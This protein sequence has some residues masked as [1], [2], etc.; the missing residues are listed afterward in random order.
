MLK[1]SHPRATKPLALEDSLPTP[2]GPPLHIAMRRGT[3]MQPHVVALRFDPGVAGFFDKSHVFF[4][5]GE[6][7]YNPG[8]ANNGS[9]V[10][11]PQTGRISILAVSGWDFAA[12]TTIPQGIGARSQPA[13]IFC[14]P[15]VVYTH[16]LETLLG[17]GL[18][19]V[20]VSRCRQLHLNP[21][22]LGK[23]WPRIGSVPG[24]E[25]PGHCTTKDS[26]R[27]T[28]R[29][30]R[31]ERLIALL[32]LVSVVLLP[33]PA[34]GA[35]LKKKTLDA[36]NL[37]ARLTEERV[38]KEISGQG[39][40]LWVDGLPEARRQAVSTQMRN[41]QV[42]IEAQQ[43]R[44]SGKEIKVPDGIIHHWVGVAF[45]PGVKLM[46]A[47]SITLDY[48]NHVRTYRP[49]VVRSK[50]LQRDGDN[51]RMH[52]RFLKKKIITV[53]VDTEH[54]VH[55][56]RVDD[57]RAH[58]WSHTTRINEVED[59]GKK[60]ER[61]LPEGRDG[62]FM[63]RMYTYWR[64]LERDSG[65]YIQCESLTLTRDIPWGLGWLIRPYVTS[66]PR[67][68]L[69]FTMEKTRAGVMARRTPTSSTSP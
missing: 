36:F 51:Y 65:T 30:N 56:V 59:Y 38:H 46:E 63:W 6:R 11:L 45:L 53:V 8:T 43:T 9:S 61:Q 47:A 14:P 35:E 58:C 67:E 62:G 17:R 27:M 12:G 54:E 1:V 2:P 3:Q 37:Y 15:P 25:L 28:P 50:L 44:Q 23:S 29:A 4:P 24:A 48:D 33:V 10:P 66:I 7:Y 32:T 20:V 41:G 60:N 68:S 18:A 49:D 57:T 40:F 16:P 21:V 64:F 42:V 22:L 34:W 55:F 69:T 52:L 19:P 31:I 26:H 39:P 5:R 13:F